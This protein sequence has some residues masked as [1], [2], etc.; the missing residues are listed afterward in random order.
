MLAQWRKS[1]YRRYEQKKR[2]FYERPTPYIYL[3]IA[4]LVALFLQ[5]Y[6]HNYNIVYLAMFFTF[7]LAMSGYYYGKENIKSLQ[8]HPIA[9][10][11]FANNENALHVKIE[12]SHESYALFITDTTQSFNKSI[13]DIHKQKSTHIPL[14]VP[15]RGHFNLGTYKL[16]S[17]FPYPWQ[18]FYKLFEFNTAIAYPEPK[19]ES[20]ETFLEQN[21]DT[22]GD[23]DE[24]ETLREYVVGDN[25]RDIHWSS[26]A[27][28]QK[29][30]VK[31]YIRLQSTKR[32]HFVLQ[33]CRGSIEHK[34]S[35]ITLWILTCEKR[36]LPFS[37]DIDGHIY[38]SQKVDVD[39]I[40]KELALY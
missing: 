21:R 1:F 27:A 16:Y 38:N 39:E 13:G 2:P 32:L 20:L 22:A 10:R 17:T 37:V 3:L 23:I 29:L 40:L 34:I 31:E 7:S 25:P 18:I 24:F 14:F 9:S 4:A 28:T 8:L 6:F 36:G 30:H 5:A 15:Q 26:F 11:Y 35:Q 12:S 33:Q 19:G